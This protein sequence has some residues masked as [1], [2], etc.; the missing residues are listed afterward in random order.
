MKR[1]AIMK[2]SAV[3]ALLGVEV[4]LTAC[5]ARTAEVNQPASSGVQGSTGMHRPPAHVGATLNLTGER[6]KTLAVTLSKVIDPATGTDGPASL[7]AAFTL[8]RC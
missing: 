4:T 3:I 6:A 7:T 1:E 2:R 5:A 8:P